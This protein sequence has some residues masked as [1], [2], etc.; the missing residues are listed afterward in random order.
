MTLIKLEIQDYCE[1]C[2]YFQVEQ[3]T[4]PFIYDEAEHTLMCQYRNICKSLYS[5][6]SND[7]RNKEGE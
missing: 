6:L 2:G 3:D 1:N 4:F 5:R 7:T